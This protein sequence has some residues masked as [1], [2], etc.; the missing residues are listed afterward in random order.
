HS[1]TTL[2]EVE[3]RE[4]VVSAIKRSNTGKG[5]IVR[6]YNP[7]SHAVE[8][9]IRPG[10]DLARAFVANLQEEEQEQLFWSGDAGEHLHVGIRAGEIKTILFQ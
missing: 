4:L 10:V 1:H 2:L 8:A 6:L 5:I 9:S 3:P 7:F